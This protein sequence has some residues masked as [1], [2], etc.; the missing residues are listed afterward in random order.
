M[1]K[2]ALVLVRNV[3]FGKKGI[4]ESMSKI[5]PKHAADPKSETQN[6]HLDQPKTIVFLTRWKNLLSDFKDFKMENLS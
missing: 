3:F 2:I 5:A 4:S 1:L 6:N